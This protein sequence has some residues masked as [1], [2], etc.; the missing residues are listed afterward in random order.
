MRYLVPH[1][2]L[3][4]LGIRLDLNPCGSESVEVKVDAVSSEAEAGL[5]QSNGSGSRSGYKILR[6]HITDFSDNLSPTVQ[7]KL[8]RLK[9]QLKLQLKLSRYTKM[10]QDSKKRHKR[11]EKVLGCCHVIVHGYLFVPLLAL[12]AFPLLLAASQALPVFGLSSSIDFIPTAVIAFKS[13]A[14]SYQ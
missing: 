3:L 1:Y 11:R 4:F 14:N 2:F 5:F 9:L 7:L 6:F 13:S 8:S 10:L 12:S